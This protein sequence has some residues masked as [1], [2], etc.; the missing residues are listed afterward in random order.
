MNITD[1]YVQ[2]I[3]QHI[4]SFLIGLGLT[5]AIVVLNLFNNLYQNKKL[6]RTAYYDSLTLCR[7]RQYLESR[8]QKRGYW[9][10]VQ[11]SGHSLIVFDIDHFKHV[12]DT[13][14]HLEGDRTLTQVASIVRRCLEK[15]MS[16]FDGAGMNSLFFLTLKLM[17]LSTLLTECGKALN[18]KR[19]FHCL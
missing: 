4:Y 10:H 11:Q 6:S 12:N 9:Q 19:W 2:S 1:Y 8:M 16:S 13:Y 7:N 3:K 18:K 15:V 14:G 17:K 5:I